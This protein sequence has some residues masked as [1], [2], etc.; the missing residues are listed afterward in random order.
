MDLDKPKRGHRLMQA[1]ARVDRVF[2]YLADGLV[3][4]YLGIADELR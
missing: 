1:F 3:V 2:N 4:E